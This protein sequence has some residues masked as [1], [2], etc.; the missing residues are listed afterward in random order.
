MDDIVIFSRTFAE[1]MMEI[2]AI[3]DKLLDANITLKASKC[4]IASHVVD[5]LGYR[6]SKDGIK[7]QERLMSAICI[8][9]RLETR[10]AVK[11]F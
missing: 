10:K 2:E 9:K 5:F 1:H 4:V 8:F 7:P 6:L 11:S 3:F